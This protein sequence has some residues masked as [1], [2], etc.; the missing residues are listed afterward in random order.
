VEDTSVQLA[1][2]ALP[3]RHLT[4]E[5]GDRVVSVEVGPPAWLHHRAGWSRQLDPLPG[6]PGTVV[7]DG[8][9]PSTTYPV[10]VAGPGMART[11]V[12]HVRTLRPPPGPL[13]SRFTTISDTHLG[14][15]SFG[16]LRE[17]V[18]VHPRCAHVEPYPE[19]CARAAVSEAA[20]W[21]SDLMLVKGD[22]TSHSRPAEFAGIRNVLVTSPLASAVQFGNHDVHRWIDPAVGLAGIE[23]A[24]PDHPVVRDLPGVRIVLGHSPVNRRS[25]GELDDDAVAVLA[26][27]VAAAAGPAVV[28]LHHAPQKWPAPTFYPPGLRRAASRRLT[29]ALKAANPATLI[30]AGHSHRSR[31]YLVDG[32]DVV[33][34]GSTKD[35]PGVWAGYAVHEGGIRQVVRRIG[36]PD[37]VAWTEASR[38]AL[39][40]QWGRWSPGRLDDRCWS[41][42]WPQ[43]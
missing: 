22:L 2:R 32:V 43:R 24:S 41:L 11:A 42:R 25:H 31:R 14:E 13:L 29:T 23:S 17:M 38:A 5:V 7:V 20:E 9:E 36:R 40:G 19:R 34:V 4:V 10:W 3:T 21:G 6:G 30:L 35:Y 27:A 28:S 1:W 15:D 33:E 16:F 12:G 26:E 18:E 39:L 8:L 37:V